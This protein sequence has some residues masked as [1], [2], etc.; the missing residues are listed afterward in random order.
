M[1]HFFLQ[2]PRFHL[3]IATKVLTSLTTTFCS[4]LEL[5]HFFWH[6]CV[7]LN[8]FFHFWTKMH[9][10]FSP[11]P[12]HFFALLNKNASL[13][14][15]HPHPHNFLHFYTKMQFFLECFHPHLY[16]FRQQG[17]RTALPQHCFLFRILSK[18]HCGQT[19]WVPCALS[20]ISMWPTSIIS[21]FEPQI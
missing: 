13:E 11:Q 16:I 1:V 21:E 4:F 19:L 5:W 8:N 6:F 10:L 2:T 17:H 7:T 14:C 20:G 12:T 3:T 9:F 18:Y 15:F